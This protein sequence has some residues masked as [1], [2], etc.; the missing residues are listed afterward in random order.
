MRLTR[1]HVTALA[2]TAGLR[3][4]IPPPLLTSLAWQESG[5]NTT[6][7]RGPKW[8]DELGILQ[9][10]PATARWL[11][12]EGDL[13]D[14]E[15]DPA[16]GFDLAGKYLYLLRKTYG[17]AW[18][19]IVSAYNA[20]H[21]IQGNFASYVRPVLERADMLKGISSSLVPLAVL[22]GLALVILRAA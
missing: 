18:A 2:A 19:P 7:K 11:G 15:R 1:D 9:I 5:W 13:R 10:R 3:W 21:P 4:G 22:A 8:I 20:G 12:F 16:L 17:P 6:P 14:L